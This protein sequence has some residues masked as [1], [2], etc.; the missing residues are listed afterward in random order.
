LKIIKAPFLF[1]DYDKTPL[2][3]EKSEVNKFDRHLSLGNDPY[4]ISREIL[5]LLIEA[6]TS[7]VGISFSNSLWMAI[8]GQNNQDSLG[9]HGLSDH[10]QKIFD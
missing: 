4:L 3:I 10:Q 2:R 8:K 6:G 5:V 1:Y 9:I 7:L